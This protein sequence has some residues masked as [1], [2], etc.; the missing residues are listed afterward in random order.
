MTTLEK[1]CKT[2]VGYSDHTNGTVVPIAAVARGACVIEK[3]LTIHK[4]LSGPDHKASL[5]PHEFKEMVQKIRDTEKALGSAIKKPTKEEEPI[6]KRV[7]KSIVAKVRI[8]QGTVLARAHLI[9]KRPGTGIPPKNIKKIVGKKVKKTILA[10]S[11][12]PKSALT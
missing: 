3:H 1:S 5:E 4:K 8:P 10:D 6:K 11:L 2:L 7:R 9:I 12:I